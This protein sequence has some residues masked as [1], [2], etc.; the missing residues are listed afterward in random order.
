[1]SDKVP[2]ELL[3]TSSHEWVRVEPDGTVVIGIT[4]FAQNHLGE[5][6]FVDSPDLDAGLDQGDEVA[7]VESVKAA[8]DVYSPLSGTVIAI[9]D[10]LEDAPSLVNSDPYGDG[11][12]FKLQLTAK[13]E[14]DDLM[15]AEDYQ[16]H[17]AE[18][19]A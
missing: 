16:S 13:E 7:V 8:A 14:L 19:E 5:L 4:D 12:L 1:M 18:E 15:K 6:V 17:L 2:S 9:N 10:D 11:W 3:Y